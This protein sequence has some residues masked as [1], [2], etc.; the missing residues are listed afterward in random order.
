MPLNSVTDV[1]F[2][3]HLRKQ[4][5]PDQSERRND[6]VPAPTQ[7]TESQCLVI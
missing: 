2:Q 6:D 5:G 4:I 3:S 1:G 7:I